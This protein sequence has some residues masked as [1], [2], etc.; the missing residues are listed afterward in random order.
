MKNTFANNLADA[1][2]D[3]FYRHVL[4]LRS[5]EVEL[6]MHVGPEGGRHRPLLHDKRQ[7]EPRRC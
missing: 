2:P 3:D 4:A 5:S 7:V 1:S 6:A